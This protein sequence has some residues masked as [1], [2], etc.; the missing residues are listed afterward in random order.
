MKP[1]LGYLAV[2]A[3]AAPLGAALPAPRT[4]VYKTIGTLAIRADVREPSSPAPRPV[5][6]FLHGG[7]LINGRR[8]SV[9]KW[10]P[11][12][13]LLAAGVVVVS[14]DYRLAPETKLPEIVTDVEDAFRWVREQGPG[15][16]GADPARVA[17]AG[18][19]AG[20]YL[21]L[22][23]GHRV[24]PVLRAVTAEMGYGDLLGD[25][26]LQPSRH[27]PHH[28]DSRLDE[29]E[30]WRQVAGP[31]IANAADRRGNGN[32]FNDFIRRA[33]QWPKAV[34]G[35]DPL[36]EA[37]RFAPYLPVRHLTRS[38]PPTFLLHGE[39]DSDVPFTEARRLAAGL[40]EHG[41]EHR[42]VGLAGVEHGFRGADPAILAQAHADLTAFLRRHLEPHTPG[43]RATASGPLP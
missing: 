8:E 15:L 2:L 38:F 5:A 30:A 33:A 1:L 41:V 20:G 4:L 6:V 19:S 39:A 7:S 37:F 35:W 14:V 22:V 18:S 13:G 43:R 10:A 28:T 3:L 27:P 36:T 9:E 34:S 12:E 23:A 17:A 40:L 29:A 16:F 42:L 24:R 25:W 31:P 11:A 21:A 32:A 26:L